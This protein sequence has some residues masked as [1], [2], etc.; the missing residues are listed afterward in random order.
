[1]GD[2]SIKGWD[3]WTP[4]GW[5][6]FTGA[7]AIRL[8]LAERSRALENRRLSKMGQNTSASHFHRKERFD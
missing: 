6:N 8:Y 4:E 2:G 5:L 3:T 1:M 7:F